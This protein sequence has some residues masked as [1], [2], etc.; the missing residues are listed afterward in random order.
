MEELT[1]VPKGGANPTKGVV[2]PLSK[3]PVKVDPIS[4][5]ILS[6]EE[7]ETKKPDPIED[8]L[9]GFDISGESTKPIQTSQ[10]TQGFK[11]IPASGSNPMEIFGREEPRENT[12]VV[13]PIGEVPKA[14][15]SVINSRPS[16]KPLPKEPQVEQLY[17]S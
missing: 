8:L 1:P 5:L 15:E 4:D 13:K 14:I 7:K 17:L 2:E 3:K 12:S 6:Y 11:G 10:G 16:K 9:S